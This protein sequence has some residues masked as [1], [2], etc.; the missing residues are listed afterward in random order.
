MNTK[1]FDDARAKGVVIVGESFLKTGKVWLCLSVGSCNFYFA[2]IQ[3]DKVFGDEDRVEEE[4][5][6]VVTYQYLDH[7]WKDYDASAH[8]IVEAAYKDW[9]Q[10]KEVD[11]RSVKSGEFIY[12]I[13][14]GLCVSIVCLNNVLDFENLTQTNMQVPP[15]TVRQIRRVVDGIAQAKVESPF[16][17]KAEKEVEAEPEEEEE[18]EGD[19]PAPRA[20]R[21]AK[22]SK[23]AADNDEDK[24]AP[25]K[26]GKKAA[27]KKDEE[28]ENDE[29]E[30]VEDKP[31]PRKKKAA[32]A[33]KKRARKADKE[34][35]EGGDEEEEEEAPKAKK[36]AKKPAAKAAPAK[37]AG[38]SGVLAGLV[39]C[40]TGINEMV[41][42]E[43]F[44]L[45][46]YTG[47]LSNPRSHYEGLIKSNGGA[48][49]GSLTKAVT[50]VITG[51][52]CCVDVMRVFSFLLFSYFCR[53]KRRRPS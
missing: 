29:D 12:S 34:E 26:R 23:K 35:E 42:F 45:L 6:H 19:K 38:G 10:A 9:L 22:K 21:A 32:A 49:A 50:H 13:G 44:V 14:K 39:F 46:F 3:V 51:K 43:M 33:P 31:A 4:E 2:I 11:S 20:K 24:P 41:L 28:D 18:E 7:I 52:V 16:K 47:K 53:A 15:H 17:K 37:K 48:V 40:I 30:E 25:R 8:G 5:E 1:K 27:A 36:A